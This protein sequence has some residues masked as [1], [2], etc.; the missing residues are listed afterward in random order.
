MYVCIYIYI[1][2]YIDF[3]GGNSQVS[4][5]PPRHFDSMSLSLRKL[6]ACEVLVRSP[7]QELAR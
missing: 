4:G 3:E 5:E 2:I 6:L 7:R 1:Y